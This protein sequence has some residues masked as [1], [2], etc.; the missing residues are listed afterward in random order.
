MLPDQQN[1]V[2]QLESAAHEP[3]VCDLTAG[4]THDL[5]HADAGSKPR[6]GR[7]GAGQN[8]STWF[9]GIWRQNALRVV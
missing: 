6:R 7:V 3:R 5:P 4:T 1:N 9:D 2:Y 8:R